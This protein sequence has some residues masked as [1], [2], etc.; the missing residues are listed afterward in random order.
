MPTSRWSDGVS[1]EVRTVTPHWKRVGRVSAGLLTLAGTCTLLSPAGAAAQTI[2]G[3]ILEE[4]AT[5]PI[6][7][8]T[9][10]VRGADTT[11]TAVTNEVGWFQLHLREPGRYLLRPAH[12]SY[13]AAGEDTVTLARHEIVTVMVRMGRAAIPLEPLVVATRTFHPLKGFYDRMEQNRRGYFVRRDFIQR[14]LALRPSQLVDMTPGIRVIGPS[15]MLGSNFTSTITMWGVGG[16]CAA[17]VF[18]DGMPVPPGITSIDELTSPDQLEG[19]EIYDSFAAAPEIFYSMFQL[20]GLDSDGYMRQCGVVAYWSRRDFYY[21]PSWIR[22]LVG[23]G[24]AGAVF[25]MTRF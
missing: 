25:L 15:S 5:T 3:V 20:H 19:V 7:M 23:V 17:N 6:A 13:A 16:R 24:L 2:R 12:M 21:R 1:M 4:G 9:V 11:Y 18:L 10:E 22:W 8:A 14:R